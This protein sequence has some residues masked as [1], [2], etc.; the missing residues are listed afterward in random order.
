MSATAIRSHDQPILGGYSAEERE[1]AALCVRSDY[2][3]QKIADKIGADGMLDRRLNQFICSATI[4]GHTREYALELLVQRS[5]GVRE[6]LG[7]VMEES[8]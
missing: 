4:L 6:L 3:D 2:Y 5:V 7:S 8:D 1:A